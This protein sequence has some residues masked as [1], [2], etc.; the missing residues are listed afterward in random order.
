PPALLR[1]L[2][3]RRWQRQA[4]AVSPR[5]RMIRCPTTHQG[6]ERRHSSSHV[7]RTTT[8]SRSVGAGNTR[9]RCCLR[10]HSAARGSLAEALTFVELGARLGY[11][12]D[13]DSQEVRALADE[14]GR[15]LTALN[16]SLRA[17]P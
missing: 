7:T 10:T 4:S 9:A 12:A 6:P 13:P 3:D 2:P 17:S 8:G 1:A 5:V 15:M 16:R 11:V 14:V